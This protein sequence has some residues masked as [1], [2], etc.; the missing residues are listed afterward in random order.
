[1]S[2]LL[3]ALSFDGGPA[4]LSGG[5]RVCRGAAESEP[6]R[7]SAWVSDG[8]V[9]VRLA[10]GDV[11]TERDPCVS[12]DGLSAI[13]FDGRI[14]NRDELS[15]LL[16]ARPVGDAALV[17]SLYQMLGAD[18]VTRIQGD[19][20]FALWDGRARS[21]FCARDPMGIRPLYYWRDATRFVCA[22]GL[23]QLLAVPGLRLAPNAGM[24][25][26]HLANAIASH[27]ETVYDGIDR[28]PHG[29][30]LT[31]SASGQI[32]RRRYWTIDP[33]RE[34]RYRT[35]AEYADHFRA[36]FTEAVRRRIPEHGPT[37][38]YLSGG[39]D[40]SAVTVVA[41]EISRGAVE[42]FSLT[43]GRDPERDEL[44]YIEDVCRHSGVPSHVTL[45]TDDLG[46]PPGCRAPTDVFDAL[47]DGPGLAWRKT[48]RDRGF[49]VVLT[50][51][52]GDHG[53]LGS[54]YRYAD[55]LRRWRFGA[56][57][58]QCLV[59]ARVHG[60][61]VAAHDL[62]AAGVWP[63]LPGRLRD[64]LRPVA[65]RVA[66]VQ[67]VPS[68]V[69][70]RFAASIALADRVRR[71]DESWTSGSAAA[72]AVRRDLESGW[73]YM[74]LETAAREAAELGLD[75][76]HPFFDRR[77]VE[78]AAAIPDDQ[79]C[80]GGLT[81]FVLR[82]AL[83]NRLPPSVRART[84]SGNGSARVARAVERMVAQGLFERMLLA[85]NGW[86]VADVVDTMVSRMRRRFHAGDRRYADDAFPLWIVGG[87]ERWFRS[88]FESGYTAADRRESA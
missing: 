17:L 27:D 15:S 59:D 43:F 21:L 81:R 79:R 33:T 65:R 71:G 46:A 55:L 78:F 9:L 28:L 32:N 74:D 58:R 67:V 41:R 40:S 5:E 42:A 80:R 31:V 16:E 66:G 84:S 73:I 72:S 86:V 34:L 53:F 8:V 1:M 14:D 69:T 29:H 30:T 7:T 12:R 88:A 39:M 51:Q 47:R 44:R 50:G 54:V 70:P 49:S 75:E 48:I 26:E 85:E 20:G 25:A 36:L 64:S 60:W 77:V 3:A 87:T 56:G 35:D 52:G 2:G 38:I 11:S 83:G 45:A 76:R 57:V 22:S 6:R 61:R 24:I 68:W 63:L 18:C 13:A 4:A 62:V 82:N 10:P 19:F 37:A 23:A